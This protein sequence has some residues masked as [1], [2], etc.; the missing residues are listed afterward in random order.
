VRATEFEE[1]QIGIDHLVGDPGSVLP[2]SRSACTRSNHRFEITI[3]ADFETLIAQGLAQAPRNA[4]MT[5]KQDHARI[6]AVPKNGQVVFIP[7]KDPHRVGEQEALRSEVTAHSEQSARFGVVRRRE[8][9]LICQS[10][11]GHDAPRPAG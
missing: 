10:I 11:D 8:A 4:E 6:G 9:Q 2:I 7:G 1:S 3:E 5:G